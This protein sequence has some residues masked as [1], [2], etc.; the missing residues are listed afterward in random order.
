MAQTAHQ[1]SNF[2]QVL[3]TPA[4][5][6]TIP[7]SLKPQLLLLYTSQPLLSQGFFYFFTFENLFSMVSLLSALKENLLRPLCEFYLRIC[8]FIRYG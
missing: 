6:Q 1:T 5:A 7:S 3:T 2:S 8:K 4:T